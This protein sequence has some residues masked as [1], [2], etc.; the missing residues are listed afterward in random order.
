MDNQQKMLMYFYSNKN[1]VGSIFG[2]VGL[3]LAFPLVLAMIFLL[4]IG[5]FALSLFL[6]V[7]ALYF[8]GALVVPTNPTYQLTFQNQT[9]VTEIEAEL[10]HLVE[11]ID[12]K[13]SPQILTKVSRIKQSILDIL[14]Y[15]VDINSADH[16]IFTIRRT[17]LDYLPETL[18]NYLNLPPAFAK[19]HVVRDGKTPHQILLEQL[20]MLDQELQ[21]IVVDFNHNNTQKLMAHGRFLE[22]RFHQNDLLGG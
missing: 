19:R 14:P 18:E 1:I 4:D 3:L 17:A 8:V 10:H 9:T 22:D 5:L 12:G 7:P 11:S 13:V 6:I 16:D 2:L 20:D 15:I 21:E